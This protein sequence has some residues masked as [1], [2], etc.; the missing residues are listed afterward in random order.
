MIHNGIIKIAN[1][2]FEGLPALKYL[3]IDKN[4]LNCD[5]ATQNIVENLKRNQVQSHIICGSPANIHGRSLS[6][7]DETDLNCGKNYANLF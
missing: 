3:Q 2:A 5:C 6:Q 7:I 4:P 1:N